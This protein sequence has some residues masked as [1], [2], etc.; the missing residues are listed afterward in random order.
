[1]NWNL[2]KESDMLP[3]RFTKKI[4]LG[5]QVATFTISE[6]LEDGTYKYKTYTLPNA[7]FDYDSI[8]NVIVSGDYSNDRM[9]AIIN[10]YLL[11]QSNEDT[12]K[13]FNDMQ[14][15]RKKAK[16]WAKDL[17]GYVKENHLWKFYGE[18]EV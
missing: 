12:T 15:F 3:S 2:A 9:Q 1:M 17:I 11:D 13:E 18:S 16:T 10:N 6:Q 8:V 4:S 5:Q 7:V 14:E